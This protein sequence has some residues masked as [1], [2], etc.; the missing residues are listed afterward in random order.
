MTREEKGAGAGSGGDAERAVAAAT[1]GSMLT[2]FFVGF[3]KIRDEP[4]VIGRIVMGG[5]CL[6]LIGLLW[7]LATRGAPEERWISPT[8]LGSP[9]EV[10][11]SFG[12]LWFERALTRNTLV[13]LKLVAK[14]FGIAALIA[15]PIGVLCGTFKRINAFF[16]PITIF[17]RNVPVVA[18]LPV[19]FVLAQGDENQKILFLFMACVAFVLFDATQIIAKVPQKYLD[20]AYTLGASRA[21]VVFKVLIPLALPDIFNSLRLLFG[22]AFGYIILAEMLSQ[23]EGGLGTLIYIS[24]K[25]GPREHV[26]LLLLVITL[27]AYLLDRI[28]FYIGKGLFPYRYTD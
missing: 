3:F 25:K 18:L 20:T 14:G 8:L 21:Q 7:W 17:G 24:Q 27:V 19:V 26:Y 13:S 1:Q 10:F 16:A 11:G 28:L 22:L 15:I 6:G 12:S 9:K 2:R 5:L 23:G 4:S